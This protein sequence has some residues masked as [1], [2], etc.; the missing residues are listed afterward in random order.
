MY[1]HSGFN[2]IRTPQSREQ[3]YTRVLSDLD[4]LIAAKI[5]KCYLSYNQPHGRSAGRISTFVR[6]FFIGDS[7]INTHDPAEGDGRIHVEMDVEPHDGWY[8]SQF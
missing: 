1:G 6:W 8:N 7:P 2:I 5:T 3:T 4:M